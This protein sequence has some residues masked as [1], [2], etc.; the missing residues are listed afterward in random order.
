MNLKELYLNEMKETGYNE[1]NI[2]DFHN[3]I[4]PYLLKL[5]NISK[6]SRIIDIGAAEGHCSL[7]AK[8][9]GFENLGVVDYVD[10]NFE[11]F[12]KKKIDCYNVDITK[13]K[14]P[15]QDNSID[16]FLFFHTIEHIFDP[17]LI[18][19]EM[20]RCL[21]ING[22][23]ILATPDWAKQI[24]TFNEDPTHIRPYI[25]SG[26]KRLMRIHQWNEIKV[27]SFGSGFGFSRLKLYKFLP[28]LAFIGKDI[29]VT[30]KK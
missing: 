3:F 28:S 16:L 5:N 15:F 17:N 1:E 14:L 26:L 8:L 27:Q 13:E 6:N 10:Y 30:C 24:K 29:L 11:K 19:S 4:I 25:K 22:R 23:M 7:T 21:K 2:S 9:N 20:K 12:R 18:I